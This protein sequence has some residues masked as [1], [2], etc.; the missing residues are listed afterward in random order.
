[1]KIAVHGLGRM[2][3][4]IAQKLIEDGHHTV[5]AHNRSL[6][7]I[8]QAA[9]VGAIPAQTKDDVVTA[10]GSDRPVVWLMLPAEVTDD[11]IAEWSHVL[12]PESIIINGG[13]SDYR[14]TKM[15]NGVVGAAGSYLIDIGVSGGLQGAENG[16]PLMCGCDHR[17]IYDVIVPIL[18][19]LVQPNGMHAYFGASGVG[20]YVKMVHNAVEYGM[21]QSLGEGYQLLREGP[22]PDT[23]LE[24]V[25]SLW[26][27][28][29]IVQSRLNELSRDIFHDNPSL[30]GISGYVAESGE[31]RW[32][33][34][35]AHSLDMTLPC[36]EQAFQVRLDTQIGKTSFAT[37]TVAAQ[38][39][40][41]GGHNINGEGAA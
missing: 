7:P 1:M 5:I 31:A 18:D 25:A 19:V 40:R 13:N 22:Y 41:F 21:M 20:H 6:E 15:M 24:N 38:R 28:G 34:E 9:V 12:P 23:D 8:Q 32:A 10:F 26:Q 29:S 39:N 17:E 14:R 30:D 2:G 3:M 4:N 37:K 35:T 11:E 33:I 36:I 16:Y 27:H